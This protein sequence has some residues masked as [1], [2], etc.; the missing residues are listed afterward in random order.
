MSIKNFVWGYKIKIPVSCGIK[1]GYSP[2]HSGT[3]A[4]TAKTLPS[5]KKNPADGGGK[6]LQC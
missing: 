5:K 1:T 2:V 6:A 4:I 3:N